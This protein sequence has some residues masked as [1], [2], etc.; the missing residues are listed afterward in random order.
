ML[1]R[2]S[3]YFKFQIQF[4]ISLTSHA[5]FAAGFLIAGLAMPHR[6]RR[7]P[8]SAPSPRSFAWTPPIRQQIADTLTFLRNAKAASHWPA[9][10]CR[11]CASPPT[12]PEYTN[13]MSKQ[14]A[15]AF[16]SRSGRPRHKGEHTYRHGPALMTEKDDPAQASFSENFHRR[17]TCAAAGRSG[18]R[19]ITGREFMPQRH[20]E[21]P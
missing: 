21:I 6:R 10:T 20:R 3:P 12:V 16:F 2:R 9:M 7:N 18:A 5:V 8:K 17:A 11:L 4:V 13:G 19:R 1:R 15:L 14:E